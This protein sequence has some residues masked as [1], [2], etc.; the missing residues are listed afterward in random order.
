LL[1][2]ILNT[3]TFSVSLI[4]VSP[5]YPALCNLPDSM[6]LLTMV[7]CINYKVPHIVSCISCSL[8]LSWV[9]IFSLAPF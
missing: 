2:R 5:A 9:R 1:T 6:S 4:T 3:S 8:H 7:N